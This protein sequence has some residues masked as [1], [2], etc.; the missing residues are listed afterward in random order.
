MAFMLSLGSCRHWLTSSHQPCC[1]RFHSVV[2]V[3]IYARH[4]PCYCRFHAVIGLDS[5]VLVSATNL[6]I[7]GFLLSLAIFDIIVSSVS[8]YRRFHSAVGCFVPANGCLN[9]VSHQPPDVNCVALKWIGFTASIM[10][11][12]WLN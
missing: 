3:I 5:L 12:A 10:A 7:V 8:C 11:C 1:N 9:V 4:Q 6:A 2:G